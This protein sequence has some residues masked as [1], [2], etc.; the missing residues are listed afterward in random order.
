MLSNRL[1]EKLQKNEPA[2]GVSIMIP[3]PQL[4]E[5]VAKL[6]FDWVLIDCEHGTINPE[7]VEV[8]AMAAQANGITP[9]ARPRTKAPADIQ[10]V[11][12]RGVMGVQ[13]PHV[14]TAVDAQA[15][16]D[17]V[18]YHPIGK[19]G[20][21]AGT[22][23]ANYGYGI[24]QSEYV[25]AANRES[26]VCVQFED[27]EAIENADE[28]LEVPNIDVFFIGPSDLSQSMGHP[29]QYDEPS[30]AHAIDSTFEKILA[31]GQVA[32]TPANED[33]IAAVLD[34]G[35]RYTYTHVTKLLGSAAAAFFETTGHRS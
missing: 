2:I 6:G 17:A 1:K 9:I 24:T 23:P 31:T 11:M 19:R 5:M 32:G 21:A 25:E 16:V 14:N 12:D 35:V 33:K 4:V 34:R 13:V 29:G 10:Q 27:R 28:I 20:L 18:K 3:S 26:L 8:L 7:T 30:V 15:V 22:R